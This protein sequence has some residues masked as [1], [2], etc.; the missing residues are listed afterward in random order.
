VAGT[1][2]VGVAAIAELGFGLLRIGLRHALTSALV[3]RGLIC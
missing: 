3:K 2:L 1:I